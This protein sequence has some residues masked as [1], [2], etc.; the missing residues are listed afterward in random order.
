MIDSL[1]HSCSVSDPGQIR[2]MLDHHAAMSALHADGFSKAL[3][4]AL[5][6]P[7]EFQKK[8]Q[9]PLLLGCP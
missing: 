5:G 6:L 1:S 7:L 3:S 8:A 2:G 4:V 9:F